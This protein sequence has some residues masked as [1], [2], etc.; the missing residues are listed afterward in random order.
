MARAT[1]EWRSSVTDTVKKRVKELFDVAGITINGKRAYDIQVHN[2]NFYARLL[3]GGSLA[4]GESYMDG[5]WDVEKLDLFCTKLFRA[6]LESRII[7]LKH[8]AAH[9][10]SR[11]ANLQSLKRSKQVAKQ[12]YD[13]GNEFYE[14]M[15]DQNMQYTC[16]YWKDAKNLEQAQ[17]DKLELV[18]KKLQLKKGEKV[19][20]LGSG[21]GGFARY[22][23]KKYGV[24]VT[25]YNISEEQVKYAKKICKGLPVRVV[26]ADYREAKGVYDK[27]VSIGLCEHIGYKN[28]AGLMK[29]AKR[30]LKDEGLF[31]LHTIGGNRSVTTTNP[32]I[33][34][35]IFPNGMI[36][37]AKQ[38][39]T[40][41]EGQF[42]IE[43]W[44]NLNVDYD[45]TLMAWYD[46][47]ERNWPK[48][49]E[50]YG[51]RFYRM[52]TYYLLGCA[53]YFRS[54]KGQLWQIVFS[55]GIDGGYR[56][57]R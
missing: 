55:Q 8:I 32:W 51:D 39:S 2:Q 19:L 37:S 1:K 12:H 14:A 26:H 24:H 41:S 54:R 25:T 45:K 40:A 6:K 36:P 52:W 4:L 15:L 13:L 43:D 22:A 9:I 46:N 30:C 21:W 50:Q 49:K 35:Y 44:H 29:L 23:A 53:G 31:L 48:F 11:V 33:S 28:Y 3:A 20:E 18:C 17:V 56:S 5:W 42:V 16:G 34:K 7:T 47:F 38:L 10:Y 27:V 57:I